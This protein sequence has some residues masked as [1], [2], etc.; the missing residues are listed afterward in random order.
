MWFPPGGAGVKRD[1][2]AAT[3]P[4]AA[5]CTRAPSCLLTPAPARSLPP[6]PSA[7]VPTALL[8][9]PADYLAARICSSAPLQ[10]ENFSL[11]HKPL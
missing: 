8:S 11:A 3:H 7:D 5:P 9:M 4:S 6:P 1:C 10:E 2:P